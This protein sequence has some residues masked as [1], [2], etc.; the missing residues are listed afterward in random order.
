M[1]SHVWGP[2]RNRADECECDECGMPMYVGDY[3]TF[4][5]APFELGPFCGD[6]CTFKAV[7]RAQQEDER[8][9]HLYDPETN[10]LRPGVT[11]RDLYWA[12]RGLPVPA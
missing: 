10:L 7:H 11:F 6:A 12:R 9:A 5:T 4:V 2:I 8:T 3:R 1:A